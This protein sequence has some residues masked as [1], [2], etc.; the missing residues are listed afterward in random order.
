MGVIVSDDHFDYHSIC[1]IS[2]IR[3]ESSKNG[4]SAIF[5]DGQVNIFLMMLNPFL[6]RLSDTEPEVKPAFCSNGLKL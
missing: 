1:S 4:C 5:T 3:D 6:P 2:S